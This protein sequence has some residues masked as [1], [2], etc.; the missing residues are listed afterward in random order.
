MSNYVINVP[1]EY[2]TQ[3]VYDIMTTAAEV[4]SG[5]GYWAD[6]RVERNEE[7]DVV[8]IW[9]IVEIDDPDEPL[10]NSCVLPEDIVYVL[11]GI[12]DGRFNLSDG[13]RNHI[14]ACVTDPDGIV[15]IDA[16]D[17]DNIVQLAI[18]DD[19]VYG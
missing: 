10:P 7:L 8:K 15:N 11:R 19:I 5:I 1:V 18:F 14:I 2:P 17:A 3:N 6:Y 4:W 16:S 9:D 12:V 13:W